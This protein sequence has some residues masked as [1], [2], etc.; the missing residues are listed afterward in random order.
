MGKSYESEQPALVAEVRRLTRLAGAQPDQA[1]AC[2]D[3]LVAQY[4]R[5]RMGHALSAALT[6]PSSPRGDSS[7]SGWPPA[8]CGYRV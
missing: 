8:D 4:G 1:M 2:F 6:R 5:L 3:A 7:D